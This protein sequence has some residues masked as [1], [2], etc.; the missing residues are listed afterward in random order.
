MYDKMAVR[1]LLTARECFN[2]AHHLSTDNLNISAMTAENKM[3]L[4]DTKHYS[5]HRVES[6]SH[7]LII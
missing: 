6:S 7:P 2:N 1:V 5:K 3:G 4:V